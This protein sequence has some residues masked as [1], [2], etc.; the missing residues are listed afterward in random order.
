MYNLVQSTQKGQNDFNLANQSTLALR[1][2]SFANSI[3][4][5]KYHLAIYVWCC[6]V[7]PLRK[8]DSDF[9]WLKQTSTVSARLMCGWSEVDTRQMFFPLSFFPDVH[10]TGNKN[11]LNV[12]LTKIKSV[13]GE[14]LQQMLVCSNLKT[15]KKNEN[16]TTET[17]L[18]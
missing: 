6:K 18:K 13:V 12:S 15:S 5:V 1:S 4:S 10:R 11:V 7:T 3:R 8:I 2:K 16:G 14:R 9:D 17:S